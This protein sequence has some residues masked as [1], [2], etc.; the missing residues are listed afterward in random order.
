VTRLLVVL[1][2]VSINL[3]GCARIIGGQDTELYRAEGLLKERNYPEAITAYRE[4]AKDAASPE[5][6]A[7]A[8]FSLASALAYYDN[9]QKDYALALQEFDQFLK[10]YPDDEKAQEAQQWSS[11]L[12]MIVELEKENENLNKNIEQYKQNIEQYK[13]NIEQYKQNIEHLNKNIEQLKQLDIMH[14]E[15]RRK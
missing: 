10:L 14:E 1:L 15:R 5:R 12:R 8:Q 4:I 11:L 6:A 3:V 13:Q 9:P 2:L 7:N